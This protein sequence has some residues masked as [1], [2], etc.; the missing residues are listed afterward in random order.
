M[1]KVTAMPVSIAMGLFVSILAQ[2]ICAQTPQ[3]SAPAKAD[4]N[5]PWAFRPGSDK[6]VVFLSGN[7]LSQLRPCGCAGGQLGG[8]EKRPAILK[9]VPASNRLSVDTGNFLA[10]T[11]QQDLIKF[12]II[13]QALELCQYDIVNL[14]EQDL[15]I[16]GKHGLLDNAAFA[17]ISAQ[18]PPDSNLKQTFEKTFSVNGSNFKVILASVKADKNQMLKAADLFKNKATSDLAILIVDGPIMPA[19]DD[20]K[21]VDLAVVRAQDTDTPTVL[22][23]KPSCPMV[24]T[25]GNRG[26][27]IGALEIT[28][29]KGAAKPQLK[30][31]AVPV[32]EN[33]PTDKALVDLY[34][35]Y[36]QIVKDE[37]LLEKSPRYLLR[38]KLEY[39]GSKTCGRKGCHEKQYDFWLNNKV[40]HKHSDAWKA[41]EEVGSDH[42]PECVICHSVGFEYKSGFVSPE[43]EKNDNTDLKNVGCENCHGAGSN[44]TRYAGKVKTANPRPG[45]EKAC[46][47]CHTPDQSPNFNSHEKE[48]F[49]KIAHW[50]EPNAPAIVK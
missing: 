37:N 1:T 44:H 25:A 19:I 46:V 22:E 27:Y 38:D 24:V 7:T 35:T 45:P 43:K 29:A 47:K 26:K 30:Y 18:V 15:S 3:N 23:A 32:S 6:I 42:D 20:L 14:N 4:S 8:F 49:E 2:G 33:L 39:V 36:Q 12:D 10:K 9:T 41:L 16:T 48:Y 21:M 17:L 13:Y 5:S 28:P 34:K 31:T 11:E 50:S 40:E